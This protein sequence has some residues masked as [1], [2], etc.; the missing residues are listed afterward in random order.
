VA[1]NDQKANQDEDGQQ[2]TEIFHLSDDSSDDS[3][4]EYQNSHI[5]D[6]TELDT[7]PDTDENDN[8][9]GKRSITRHQAGEKRTKNRVSTVPISTTS[10]SQEAAIVR[11]TPAVR[12]RII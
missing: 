9:E 11:R 12:A 7:E 4:D 6:Q 2:I 1:Y 3:S 8:A 5:S 10:G